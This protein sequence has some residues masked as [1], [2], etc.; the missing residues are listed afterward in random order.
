MACG[1]RLSAGPVYWTDLKAHADRGALW[2][3][4]RTLAL[5]DV[6]IAIAEDDA[7]QVKV[8]LEAQLLVRATPEQISDCAKR[9]GQD[10]EAVVVAP[11]VIV[12]ELIEPPTEN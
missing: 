8:W 5:L 12:R 9:T 2:F 11:Y 1:I 10:W 6:A 7:D 3:I 4:D